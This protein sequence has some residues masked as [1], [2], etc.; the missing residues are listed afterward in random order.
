M[1]P[2]INF[3]KENKTNDN[4]ISDYDNLKKLINRFENAVTAGYKEQFDKI[5]SRTPEEVKSISNE[6]IEK[7][8]QEKEQKQAAKEEE[9]KSTKEVNRISNIQSYMKQLIDIVKYFN[10]TYPLYDEVLEFWKSISKLRKVS[11]ISTDKYFSMIKNIKKSGIEND[12]KVN[13]YRKNK[14]FNS[15]KDL[16]AKLNVQLGVKNPEIPVDKIKV[17]QYGTFQNK[18]KYK[19]LDNDQVINYDDTKYEIVKKQLTT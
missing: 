10:K 6:N 9:T 11:D 5:I 7:M 15:V 8:K 19:R 18:P 1:K 13:E 17:Y 14:N 3:I 12:K 16:I 4:F 2:Y